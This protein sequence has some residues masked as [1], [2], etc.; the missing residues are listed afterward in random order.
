[1]AGVTSAS[2]FDLLPL[3]RRSRAILAATP[4]RTVA[5][6]G[7]ASGKAMMPEKQPG[8]DPRSLREIPGF[9]NAFGKAVDDSS[10]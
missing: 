7:E 8:C 3:S 5:D 9:V 2:H 4:F 6:L 10:D 1:M